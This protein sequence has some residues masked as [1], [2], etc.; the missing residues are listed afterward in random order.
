[1]EAVGLNENHHCVNYNSTLLLLRN[2]AR[3]MGGT[4]ATYERC[5]NYFVG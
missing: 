3:P 1:M 2:D 5:A 4:T